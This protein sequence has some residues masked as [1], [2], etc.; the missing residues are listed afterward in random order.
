MTIQRHDWEQIPEAA[1]ALRRSVFI[2]EQQVPPEL[3]WDETDALATHYTLSD[4]SGRIQATARLYPTGLG[5]GGVGRMAVSPDHRSHGLGQQLMQAM[6][7]DA[8]AHYDFLELSAQEQAQG[9]YQRMGFYTV[10]DS[11]MEAGIPHRAMRCTGMDLIARVTHETDTPMTLG[12]DTTTWPIEGDGD[13]L[14]LLRAL[15]DQA[16]RRLW[17]YDQQLSHSLYDDSFLSDALSAL[18]RR[19]RF[20]EIRF[21]IHDDAPLV[22]RRHRLVTLLRRLPSHVSLRLINTSH[23]HEDTPFVLADES[24][25]L[26]RHEFGQPQGFARFNASRRVRPLAENFE[27]IWE[28]G[29]ASVELRE[30]PL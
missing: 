3:E 27:R 25:L 1:L 28:Q 9:F 22:Q 7:A 10:S 16:S 14:Q 20:S 19:S 30:L 5:G 13:H 11:Y 26:Y 23:P 4:E 12:T 24:G 18:A 29:T 2:Q 8:A 15:A 6:L 21:L 17:I